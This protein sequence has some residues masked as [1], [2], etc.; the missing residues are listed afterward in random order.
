[1]VAAPLSIRS[2]L[3]SSAALNSISSECRSEITAATGGPPGGRGGACCKSTADRGSASQHAVHLSE[4]KPPPRHQIYPSGNILAAPSP[5]G[6]WDAQEGLVVPL[7][8]ESIC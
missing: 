1:M 4:R 2:Q 6:L 3:F 7:Q 8:R 5:S